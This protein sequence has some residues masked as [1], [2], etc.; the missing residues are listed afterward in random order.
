VLADHLG[1]NKLS[2]LVTVTSWADKQRGEYRKGNGKVR[3]RRTRL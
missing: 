1:Q 3:A 2:S